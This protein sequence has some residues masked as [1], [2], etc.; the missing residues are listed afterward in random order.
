MI[1]LGQ[2]NRA[3]QRET[4][5]I[6]LGAVE[7]CV[8]AVERVLG[9]NG[10]GVELVVRLAVQVVGAR[11]ADHVEDRTGG[12]TLGGIVDVGLDLQFLDR[13]AGKADGGPRVAVRRPVLPGT[14]HAL[15]RYAIQR[16][17]VVAQAGA[18]GAHHR[19][20]VIPRRI[21][22]AQFALLGHARREGQDFQ[23]RAA[24]DGEFVQLG[25]ADGRALAR[26]CRLQKLRPGD[27][28][29]PLG[30]LTHLERD[31]QFHCL[32]DAQFDVGMDIELEPGLARG[33][34]IATRVQVGDPE[35]AGFVCDRSGN[36]AGCCVG[37][38]NSRGRDHGGTRVGHRSGN[39]C[40]G[41]LSESRVGRHTDWRQQR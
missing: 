8:G 26:L 19:Q 22:I 10:R 23:D 28:L 27:D 2:D 25:L 1:E 6:L 13:I 14:T 20:S 5:A 37:G 39:G 35:V 36:H 18:V 12:V 17:G 3:T 24:L 4:P 11:S 15:V 32:R 9:R 29:D 21:R 16:N 30:C 7:I 38:L 40:A 33:Y 31:L 41:L 34:P